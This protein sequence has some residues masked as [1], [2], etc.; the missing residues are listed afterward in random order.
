MSLNELLKFVKENA[1]D[2][3]DLAAVATI[4][5]SEAGDPYRKALVREIRQKYEDKAIEAERERDFDAL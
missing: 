4:E 3:S 5:K 1:V 2:V